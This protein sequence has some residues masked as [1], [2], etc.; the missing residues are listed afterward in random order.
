[1]LADPSKLELQYSL[2][3]GLQPKNIW[4][5]CLKK[6]SGILIYVGDCDDTKTQMALRCFCYMH[7]PRRGSM[8]PHTG[9]ETPVWS[10]DRSESEVKA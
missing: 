10:G 7:F 3:L 8:P 6:N 9:D 1:M 4:T 5:L 2:F